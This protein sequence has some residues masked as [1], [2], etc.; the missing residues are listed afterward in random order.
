[1]KSLSPDEVRSLTESGGVDLIDVRE[2]HEWI[3]GHL[4][5]A[6]LVPLGV[7][8]RD[9][10]GNVRGERAVFV[11]AHG[12]RSVT[13]GVAAESAGVPEVFSLDGGIMWWVARGLPLSYA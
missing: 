2:P 13:A 4:P 12:L 11:C 3:G 8:L 6:R 1:M 9:P 5:G 7:F 10:R